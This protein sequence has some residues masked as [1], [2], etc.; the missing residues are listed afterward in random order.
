MISEKEKEN[1]GRSEQ[2]KIKVSNTSNHGDLVIEILQ[3][4]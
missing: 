4:D 1:R 3:T 2:Q